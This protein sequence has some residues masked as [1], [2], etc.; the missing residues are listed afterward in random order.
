MEPV[1]SNYEKHHLLGKAL[2][3]GLKKEKIKIFSDGQMPI[4]LTQTSYSTIPSVDIEVGDRGS[5]ISNAALNKI[6]SG[7]KRGVSYAYKN[8]KN[9]Y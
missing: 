3:K 1:K 7:L 2:I 8:L 5:D 6:A 9:E 4:D